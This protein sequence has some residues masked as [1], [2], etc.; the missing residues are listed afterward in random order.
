M[1]IIKYVMTIIQFQL[2]SQRVNSYK[3]G[4]QDIVHYVFNDQKNNITS[5]EKFRD[6]F[7]VVRHQDMKIHSY[8]FVIMLQRQILPTTADG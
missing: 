7:L 1:T 2:Y 5:A 3:N 6:V 8:S 4:I